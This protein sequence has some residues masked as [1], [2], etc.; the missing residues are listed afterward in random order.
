MKWKSKKIQSRFSPETNIKAAK[1]VSMPDRRVVGKMVQDVL[2]AVASFVY[3]EDV[4]LKCC[5]AVRLSQG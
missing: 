1:S 5:S 4:N 3:F 2:V